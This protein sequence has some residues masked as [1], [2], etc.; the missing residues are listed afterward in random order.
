MVSQLFVGVRLLVQWPA[1]EAAKL[2]PLHSLLLQKQTGEFKPP[3]PGASA[4]AGHLAWS[5]WDSGCA[6][7]SIGKEDGGDSRC[8]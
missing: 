4:H 3:P 7:R 6:K 5:R 1:V 2:R 8:G